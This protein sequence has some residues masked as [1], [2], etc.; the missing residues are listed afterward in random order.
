MKLAIMQPYFFP[1]TGYWQLLDVADR[2][3]IYDDVN[4]IKG[5]WINRNRILINGQPGYI[6]IPLDQASPNK[7]I[8]DI[9]MQASPIWRKKLIKSIENAYR[10]AP[11]YSEVFPIIEEVI[12]Y[13]TDNLAEFITNQLVTMAAYLG[14]NTKFVMTSRRYKNNSLT[15]Q[16]RVLNICNR[17]KASIY[18][19]VKAGQSLYDVDA[20]QR[21]GVDLQVIT[22]RPLP[23]RQRATGFSPCLSIIDTLM[24]VGVMEYKHH[25]NEYD[26]E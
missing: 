5:G 10:K 20:F 11:F 7:R 1:Y 13:N 16:E 18:I 6:T 19:N 4:Y 17:E 21:K 12:S 2:F 14:I 15:G 3:V 23:Y 25:L 9:A 22:T 8:C 26:L 24:E